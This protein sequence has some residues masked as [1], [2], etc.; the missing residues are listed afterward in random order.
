[1]KFKQKNG[2]ENKMSFKSET[3]RKTA[4]LKK[5]YNVGQVKESI[6]HSGWW[7]DVNIKIKHK[8]LIPVRY[9]H[10]YPFVVGFLPVAFESI[11]FLIINISAIYIFSE[12]TEKNTP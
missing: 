12:K 3:R 8:D 7:K 6:L 11:Q 9:I 2:S 10:Y 5:N 1:M 4:D